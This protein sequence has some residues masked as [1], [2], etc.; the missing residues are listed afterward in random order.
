MI[1]DTFNL[2]TLVVLFN[3]DQNFAG[4]PLNAFKTSQYAVK[5][6]AAA[7]SW[8]K[9]PGRGAAPKCPLC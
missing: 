6:L 1:S 7:R 2:V 5:N 8:L 4:I 9:I 3:R